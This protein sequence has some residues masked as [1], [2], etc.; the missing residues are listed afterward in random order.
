LPTEVVLC[1][2]LP[3]LGRS[4][5]WTSTARG[6]RTPGRPAAGVHPCSP[7]HHDRD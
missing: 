4:V 1:S 3:L 5:R 2:C 6:R 7:L